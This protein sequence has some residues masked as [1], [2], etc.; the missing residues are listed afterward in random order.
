MLPAVLSILFVYFNMNFYIPLAKTNT[1]WLTLLNAYS[2]WWTMSR[3]RMVMIG[4]G[5]NL[6]SGG[7]SFFFLPARDYI[8]CDVWLFRGAF[9]LSKFMWD[10]RLYLGCSGWITRAIFLWLGKC[11]F[12]WVTKHCSFYGYGNSWTN[13]FLTTKDINSSKGKHKLINFQMPIWMKQLKLLFLIMIRSNKSHMYTQNCQT[14]KFSDFS[15]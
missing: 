9:W 10:F 12:T 13:I 14:K 8:D 3:F 5:G 7:W 6:C 11:Y 15:G 4:F 1:R 2:L